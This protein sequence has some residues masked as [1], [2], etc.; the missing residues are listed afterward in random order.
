MPCA[1]TNS[2]CVQPHV[3]DDSGRILAPKFAVFNHRVYTTIYFTH[4]VEVITTPNVFVVIIPI[5]Q[6]SALEAPLSV[7]GTH[8]CSD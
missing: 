1:D 8:K 6:I 4:I 5:S 3:A 7:F 2:A